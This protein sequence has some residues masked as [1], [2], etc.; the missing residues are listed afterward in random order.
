[1]LVRG[2]LVLKLPGKRVEELVESG[3]GER[4]DAGKGK[5]MREWLALSPT[6]G[7]SWMALAREA[8]AFVG[9]Q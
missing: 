2:V 7:K 8:M 5:P 3:D 9:N 1:M 4:F 6:S